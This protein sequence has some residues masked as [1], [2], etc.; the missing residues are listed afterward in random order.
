VSIRC[1][2][3]LILLG[4]IVLAGT[5]RANIA[6]T[7]RGVSPSS[8]S[9]PFVTLTAQYADANGFNDLKTLE[10]LLNTT[11][12]SLA[13]AC[14]MQFDTGTNL[15]S[16]WND[17]GTGAI[18]SV[19]GGATTVENSQ[20]RISL[21]ST[22]KYELNNFDI[23]VFITFKSFLG[24][25]NTYLRAE[26][27]EAASSGWQQPGTW[28]VTANQPP[29]VASLS[30]EAGSGTSQTF[31]LNFTDPDG[32]SD[33]ASVQI[34]INNFLNGISSCYLA[35]N[36]P[37]DTL[38]L[39]KDNGDAGHPIGMLLRNGSGGALSNSQCT[40]TWAGSSAVFSGNQLTLTLALTFTSA[41]HGNKVVYTAAQDNGGNNTGW[42]TMGVYGVTG[43]ATTYPA[44]VAVQPNYGTLSNASI[45]FTF[46][47]ATS[48][49]NLSSVQALINT[50]VDGRSACYVAYNRIY[51]ELFL[52]QDNGDA[53]HPIGMPLN[54]S[55]TLS[56]SQCSIA[57][58]GSSVSGSG[59]RLT[60]ILNVTFTPAF[61]GHRAIWTATQT[62]SG[63]N[64]DWQALG[65]WLMP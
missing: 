63:G 30:P 53:G 42:I 27:L 12:A 8:G 1:P 36:I 19:S 37:G 13:N 35:Y 64:S 32:S 28:S 17:A 56:N 2:S 26:D 24:A 50:A 16:L 9:G 31:T 22:S 41:F 4:V 47:D 59:Q 46:D 51:Q 7:I 55:G 43:A 58:A 40:V 23:T 3:K 29:S 10:I 25:K 45:T 49:Q 18:G 44:A 6:P 48:Y 33:L 11:S 57:G 52:V 20:C 54:G 14:Y 5:L 38:Y 61:A 60:L 62:F 15:L 34:L 65:A 21:S 39:V